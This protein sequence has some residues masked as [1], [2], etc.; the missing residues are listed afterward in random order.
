MNP[1][2]LLYRGS[3]CPLYLLGRTPP[4][5]DAA[6]IPHA[7]EDGSCQYSNGRYNT[8]NTKGTFRIFLCF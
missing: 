1:H 8:Q 4:Q 3:G 6:P 5:E 2:Y 7:V